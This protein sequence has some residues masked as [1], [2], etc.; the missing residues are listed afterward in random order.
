LT[1]RIAYLIEE[2]GV[3]PSNILAITFTNKAANEMKE[4]AMG[5]LK[6]PHDMWISTFHSACARIL[7]IETGFLPGYK[8]NF[9][10]YDSYDQEKIIKECL[11]ELNYNE[12]NYPLPLLKSGT[13][14]NR[15]SFRSVDHKPY[16]TP[17][18]E[19][20]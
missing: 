14:L 18:L 9:V 12:K 3:H 5:L 8:K 2:K 1:Y 6:K 15:C 13:A 7:R 16:H 17:P 10:I 4:R 11:K 19:H 20:R